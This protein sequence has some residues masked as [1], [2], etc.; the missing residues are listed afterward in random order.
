MSSSVTSKR[1][2]DYSFRSVSYF[3]RF[4]LES[5]WKC[6]GPGG[7]ERENRAIFFTWKVL[8]SFSV[9]LHPSELEV[10]FLF[11]IG[12]IVG[13]CFGEENEAGR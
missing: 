4:G 5:E 9:F 11:S 12:N 2:G 7:Q 10:I 8:T 6:G 13:S 3:V 1:K